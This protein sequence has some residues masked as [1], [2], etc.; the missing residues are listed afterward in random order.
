MI[1]EPPIL[2]LTSSAFAA[3]SAAAMRFGSTLA[4]CLQHARADRRLVDVGRLHGE[5]HAGRRQHLAP[6]AAARG[7]HDLARRYPSLTSCTSS[8]PASR[9]CMSFRIVAADSS[10][11]R[12]V[13]SMTGQ[14]FC[15]HTLRE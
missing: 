2:P 8:F 1:S 12:R 10:T 14:R 6:R 9:S 7:Q 15:A 11:E 3:A 13:T 4:S 5:G